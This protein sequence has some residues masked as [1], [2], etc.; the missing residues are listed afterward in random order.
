[1]KVESKLGR[2]CILILQVNFEFHLCYSLNIQLQLNYI[3]QKFLAFDFLYIL[4]KLNNLLINQKITIKITN[5]VFL[6]FKKKFLIFSFLV[7]L[8]IIAVSSSIIISCSEEHIEGFHHS[9][10]TLAHF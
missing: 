9:C 6:L 2:L 10:S 5:S 4:N 1:M 7:L 3:D 8:L